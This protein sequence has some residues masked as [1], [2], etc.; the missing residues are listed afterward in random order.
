MGPAALSASEL[1]VLDRTEQHLSTRGARE[2]LRAAASAGGIESS[3]SSRVESSRREK[4]LYA[5]SARLAA[6]N[7][8]IGGV[9]SA[10][11]RAYILFVERR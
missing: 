4:V 2:Q 7:S 11:G 9:E 5:V 6:V 10:G 8:V 3:R 1:S